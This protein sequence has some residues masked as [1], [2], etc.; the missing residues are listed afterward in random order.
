[1]AVSEKART[2]MMEIIAKNQENY[3]DMDYKAEQRLKNTIFNWVKN[4]VKSHSF[5]ITMS[6]IHR[7]NIPN[8]MK[9][10]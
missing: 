2:K 1:M 5:I 8:F 6:G 4:I 9:R 3:K 7:E 10:F